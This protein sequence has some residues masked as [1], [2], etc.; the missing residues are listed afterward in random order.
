MA[1]T[2]EAK[3]GWLTQNVASDLLYLLDEAEVGL[4]TQ[5]KLCQDYK[6]LRK[7][8]AIADTRAELR[9]ALKTEYGLDGSTNAAQR[10]EVASSKQHAEEEVKM[11]A[12]AKNLGVGRPLPHTERS[13]MKKAVEKAINDRLT[14]KEEPSSEYL[15]QKLEELEQEEPRA[16]AL[17]QVQSRAEAT[18]LKLQTSLDSA[19]KITVTRQKAKGSLPAEE[20]RAKLKLEGIAWLMVAAR[21]RNKV[22]QNLEMRH[23]ARF[24]DYVLGEKCYTLKVPQGLR[25]RRQLIPHGRL[26]CS[27]NMRC[28]N[29]QFGKRTRRARSWGK[30]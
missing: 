9:E 30:N 18:T 3:K 11:R 20:L 12:E 14:E 16:A 1:A 22:L 4:D 21:C 26:F 2:D 27:T 25:A 29:G 28:A 24:A 15:A 7:L 5:Y 8:S 10:S 17:D 6:T 23:W 13:A 19:G